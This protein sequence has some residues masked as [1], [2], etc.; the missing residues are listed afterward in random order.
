MGIARTVL[1]AGERPATARAADPYHPHVCWFGRVARDARGGERLTRSGKQISVVPMND[2]SRGIALERKELDEVAR[3]VLDSGYVVMGSNHDAF[4]K[5]LAAY[6]G[7]RRVLGVA[8]GTDALELAFKAVMPKGK[9]TVLTAANAGGYSSTAARRAGYSVVYSDIDP[10]SLC[11]STETVTEALTPEV[12]IV[13]VTHLY[14]NFTDIGN[15]VDYC[16]ERG[17]RV[18]EDCAHAIGA[19]RQGKAA[20]TIADVAATSFYPTKNLAALGDGGAVITMS[21]EIAERVATLRQYGWSSKYTV[22][23]AGGVNSRLDEIQAAFLRVRLPLLDK[24]NERRRYIIAR[25]A[26]AAAHGPI[27]VLPAS[28]TQH[29]GHLAVAMSEQREIVRSRLLGA[30]V[31]TDIHFP[32]PDHQ[33]TGFAAPSQA[34]PH[35]ERVSQVIFSLPCFPELTE[36]EVD[37]VCAALS[38]VE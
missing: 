3:R 36:L 7:A 25:Y 24:R 6:L 9:H 14:G 29:V 11:L 2:L 16:H 10:D 13:V 1:A 26:A 30:G 31:Q 37:T 12:G 22:G 8:S 28:G 38:S 4:Q 21:T 5:E 32:I 35:T 20:G 15:L 34:L 18:V 33:Q 23:V 17:V 27:K 19:F